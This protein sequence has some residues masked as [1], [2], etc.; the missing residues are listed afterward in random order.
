MTGEA[1][2]RRD[3]RVAF[4]GV[5]IIASYYARFSFSRSI[6]NGQGG[7]RESSP[8]A[9]DLVPDTSRPVVWHRLLA[10]RLQLLHGIIQKEVYEYSI[11][12]CL[13]VFPLDFSPDQLYTP[14]TRCCEIVSTASSGNLYD[15]PYLE[16]AF[17]NGFRSQ[18]SPCGRS[19][20]AEAGY[21][22]CIPAWP[23]SAARGS[24]QTW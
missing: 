17:Q 12:L 14:D 8:V 10:L 2:N 15:H 6:A 22:L 1:L 16:V 4:F 20:Y 18:S 9:F 13:W 7:A 3:I 11:Y 5:M 21:S 19:E 24:P 23:E